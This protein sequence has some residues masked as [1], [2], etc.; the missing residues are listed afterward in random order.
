VLD[1]MRVVQCLNGRRCALCGSLMG[2]HIHFIGGPACVA[3]RLFHDPPMH[4]DC[5]VFA[6]S[7]CPHMA[8]PKGKYGKAPLPAGAIAVSDLARAVKSDW[9]ALLHT[10]FYSWE[11]NPED[12][13]I[14]VEASAWI[15]VQRWYNGAPASPVLSDPLVRIRP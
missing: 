14:Y 15:D 11:R 6:L 5:A 1:D 7:T 3:N 12:H 8:T 13:M 9:F 10:D 2:R 4:R